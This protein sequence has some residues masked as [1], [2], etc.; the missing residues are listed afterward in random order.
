M[1]PVEEVWGEPE[2]WSPAEEW[3]PSARSGW[4]AAADTALRGIGAVGRGI[5][6]VMDV[7]R[8][9]W[10]DPLAAAGA[11]G[12][13]LDPRIIDPATGVQRNQRADEMLLEAQGLG[14]TAK[15]REKG[16]ATTR[17]YE[18]AARQEFERGN[19]GRALGA[20]LGIT[21]G[22]GT[23]GDVDALVRQQGGEGTLPAKALRLGE[24]VV[25]RGAGFV[26][27][28]LT[29]PASVLSVGAIGKVL[30]AGGKAARGARLH[31][32]CDGVRGWRWIWQHAAVNCRP[33]GS[34]R[35]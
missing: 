8:G 25:A 13:G 16:R 23:L 1:S 10:S 6:A 22:M 21:T 19:W 30:G 17:D 15:E 35:T 32:S 20:A 2:V 27:S 33:T 29:D 34:S 14:A 31:D 12:Q 3:R 18:A 5:G 4:R 28:I 24:D 26:D 11:R 9:L 7:P